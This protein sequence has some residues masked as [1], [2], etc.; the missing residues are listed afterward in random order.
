MTEPVKIT[1]CE[2]AVLAKKVEDLVEFCRDNLKGCKT[3]YVG[4]YPRHVTK[5]CEDAR[6]M[7]DDDTWLLHSNRRE[8]DRLVQG[9][10]EG[11]CE[12]VQWWETIGLEKEPE[13]AEVKAKVVV[14][15]DN[16]HLRR[17]KCKSAAVF[18]CFS[19]VGDEMVLVREGPAGKRLCT[20][21]RPL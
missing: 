8:F 9:R 18:L 6:H 5:S 3:T 14:S 21:R 7:S 12:V 13:L 16:V 1:L 20:A 15:N 2:R 11:K 17:E 4:L 10:L 19:S